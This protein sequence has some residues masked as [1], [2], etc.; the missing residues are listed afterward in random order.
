[1][2]KKRAKKTT[3]GGKK[4]VSKAAYVR[5]F[6]VVMP[7]KEVVANA[8]SQ[9]V[10]LTDAYVYNV[11]ATSRAGQKSSNDSATKDKPKRLTLKTKRRAEDRLL[12]VATELGLA[13]A[14]AVLQAEHER[15]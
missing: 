1:M 8:K 13:R 2:R 10:Q 5:S 9:G 7:A 15:S 6:P 4:I 11:R 12:A 14:I 3:T